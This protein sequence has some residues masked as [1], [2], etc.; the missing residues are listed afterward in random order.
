MGRAGAGKTAKIMQE[1]RS[2]ALAGLTGRVLLVPEQYSHEAERE[3]CA[4]CGDSMSLHAE[5]LSFTRLAR[6]IADMTGGHRRFMSKSA[7]ALTTR[8]AVPV[9]MP[10]MVC[11]TLEASDMVIRPRVQPTVSMMSMT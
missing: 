11:A 9:L 5:V 2:D 4:A 7:R 3:L 1:L 8:A 6:R 10:I